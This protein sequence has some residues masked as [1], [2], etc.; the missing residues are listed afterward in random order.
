[1]AL[2][3]VRQR[4]ARKTP[5]PAGLGVSL[6]EMPWS[7]TAPALML[8]GACGAGMSSNGKD[9]SR[10]LRIRRSAATESGA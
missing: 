9:K 6:F 1:M 7:R 10:R 2:V 8:C 5:D 3:I 4:P